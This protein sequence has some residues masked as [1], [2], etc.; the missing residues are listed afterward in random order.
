MDKIIAACKQT[1][2]EAVH[3]GYGFLSENEEFSRRLEEERIVFIGPK[4]YSMA[5]MGDKIASK[6][7]AREAR[8]NTIPGYND[9]IETPGAGRRDRPEDRLPGD[10]QGLRRRRRQGPARGLERQGNRRG[11]RVLPDGGQ[12]RLRRRPGLHREV[13]RGAAA[14]RDPG[15][16]RR[17]RQRGLPVGARVLDPAPAPEGDRGGPLPFLDDATRRAMG[18][19]A[20][21][22]AKAVRLPVRRHRRVRRREG[23]EL[24][25]PGD[26]HPPAGGA[27]GDRDD[28]RARPRRADDPRRRRRTTSLHPGADPARGLG[29]RMPHQRRGPVPRL[30]ALHRSPGPLPAAGGRARR[31]A[32]GHGRLRGRRDLH[33]LR[34]DDRQAHHPRRNPRPG[35]RPDARRCSTPSSSAASRRT[36]PSRR[37]S[38][39]TR[40]SSPAISTPASSPRS[41]PRASI[42]RRSFT[43]IPCCSRPSP[44]TPAVATFIGRCGS[45][46]SSRATNVGSARSGSC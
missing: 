26:E 16:G 6:K 41:S 36:S 31:G 17:P 19:Q 45:P 9:P 25:L 33:L 8:V 34:L 18:E 22:L 39:G 44:P 15:A 43:K 12:E 30:P 2:A 28:H 35:H 42:P 4:H 7:L 29:A 10:D 3:P 21:A 37:R 20:V 46:G 38:S 27:P 24:L 40:G 11:L 32:R 13:R 14:H 1:G 23:Q 5:A